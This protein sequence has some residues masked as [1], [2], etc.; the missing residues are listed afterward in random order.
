MTPMDAC[1]RLEQSGLLLIPLPGT[2]AQAE[3]E[4]MAAWKLTA[5]LCKTATQTKQALCP[6]SYAAP[7]QNASTRLHAL[8]QQ[9]WSGLC[10]HTETDFTGNGIQLSQT[11]NP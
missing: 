5:Q 10:E 9:L 11:H 6:A 1:R 7:H 2:Q 8:Q 3:T 4:G